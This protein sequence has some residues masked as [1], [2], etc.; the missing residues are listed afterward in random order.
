MIVLRERIGDAE[1]REFLLMIGLQKKAARIVKN[2]GA[3]FPNA[4]DR[5][6]IFLQRL[7]ASNV[8]MS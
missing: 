6:F 5:E 4:R 8:V 1:I 2:L 3:Q 7:R